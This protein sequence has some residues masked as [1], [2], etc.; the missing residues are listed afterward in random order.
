MEAQA[1]SGGVESVRF[2][3]EHAFDDLSVFWGVVGLHENARHANGA[4]VGFDEEGHGKVCSFK[5]WGGGD[6]G[7]EGLKKVGQC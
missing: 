1:E 2:T 7:L 5:T 3:S 4:P 6:A